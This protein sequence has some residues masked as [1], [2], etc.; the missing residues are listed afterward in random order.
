MV[1]LGDIISFNKGFAFSSKDYTDDNS[2]KMVV[3][4]SDF[5]MDSISRDNAIFVIYQPRYSSYI[6]GTDDVL[7]QTVGSWANNP[8]SI[9]GKVVRVPEDCNG[10]LLNQNI[11]RLIPTDAIDKRYLFY[12]L[13]GNKFSDYCVIRGQGAANQASITLQTISKFKFFMH[14]KESQVRIA[15]ILYKYDQLME[16]NNKRIRSLENL[17]ESIY[18]E[19][20]IRFRFPN[21]KKTVFE[22]GLP[23]GW[24]YVKLNAIVNYSRG[25]SYSSEEIDCDDGIN[26]INLKNIQAFGGFR[27]DGT[28]KYNGKYKDSQIVKYKDLIMGVTDMTQDRRTVGHVALVPK[29]N[30]VISADLI[31]LMSR[32]NTI[33]LYSMFRFGFYS[34]SFSQ[35]GNGANV[36]HLKPESIRNQKVLLPSEE[37]ISNYV[38]IVE[39]M[40][41]LIEKLNEQNDNLLKQ[42]DSLLPRLMGGKLSVEGK[43]IV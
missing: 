30:G 19:W 31:K 20:F 27:R 37:V 11:V 22:N 7:V 3:R 1:K 8:L 32:I 34:L 5:T 36:I 42:R 15:N 28:K 26:L 23:K 17:I 33:F 41:D 35:F 38:S 25:V 39:P 43:E 14:K 29:V 18:K 21:Y 13:K 2:L 9:V 6:L 12:A 10:D 16:N 4:I 24:K 40:I